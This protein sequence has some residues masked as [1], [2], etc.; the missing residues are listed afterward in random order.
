M[1]LY[2]QNIAVRG[3]VLPTQRGTTT[4]VADSK[5]TRVGYFINDGREQ[6]T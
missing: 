1:E 3:E 6:Q 2:Q 5:Y 4:A